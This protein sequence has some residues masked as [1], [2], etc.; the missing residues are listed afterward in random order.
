MLR[1]TL[2]VILPEPE[3]FSVG[4]GSKH[5]VFPIALAVP[6]DLKLEQVL[7]WVVCLM[8]LV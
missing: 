7:H 5:G 4:K 2:L 8:N 1:A 3:S 6:T